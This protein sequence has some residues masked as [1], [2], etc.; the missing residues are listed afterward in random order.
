[1]KTFY[2]ICFILLLPAL[3]MSDDYKVLIFIGDSSAV[4]E[5]TTLKSFEKIG[6]NTFNFTEVNIATGGTRPIAGGVK[7]VDEVKK[8]NLK[9]SDYNIIWFAW[10]GP[11]H[12]GDYFLDGVEEDLLKF[13][14]N[15]G[16]IYISAFDDNY[17]DKKGNQIGTWMPIEKY[18]C[19][20]MN[21][22]DSDV[23]ITPE[24]E[25][26]SLFSKPNK[27]T[28]KELNA[29]TLDDNFDPQSNE[30]ITLALRTDNKKPAIVQL[31]YGKGAY[32]NCCIDAR[33]T[34]PAANPLIENMLNYMASLSKKLAVDYKGKF[35]LLWGKIKTI[36]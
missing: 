18:P 9:F 12:D 16:I 4:I 25:K 30:Y 13:V 21:T 1:M 24:G 27:L 35:P 14:E 20:V 33:S 5:A 11:G 31:N 6:E 3:A 34:F 32:I 15:G 10:N 19:A 26:T 8:G 36:L 29:L 7:P 28:N 23:E 17:R 2:I 22:G